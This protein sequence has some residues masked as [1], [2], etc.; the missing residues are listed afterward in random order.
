MLSL[1]KLRGYSIEYVPDEDKFYRELYILLD[2]LHNR[3]VRNRSSKKFAAASHANPDY[4]TIYAFLQC[5]PNITPRDCGD[6]L[7]R[8]ALEI[9][10]CCRGQ[11]ELGS[12]GLVAIFVLKPNLSTTKPWLKQYSSHMHRQDVT[13]VSWSWEGALATDEFKHELLSS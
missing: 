1:E 10:H 12:L 13:Y 7:T 4:R 2:S 11:E 5:T 6:C 8:S 9:Q 3:T